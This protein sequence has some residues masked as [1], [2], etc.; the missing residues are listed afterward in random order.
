MNIFLR[1]SLHFICKKNSKLP[2]FPTIVS[3]LGIA[4]G[5]LSFLTVVTILN[6]FQDQMKSIISSINPNLTIFSPMGISDINFIEKKIKSLIGNEIRTMSPFIYQESILAYGNNT[7]AVYIRAIPG[8]QSASAKNLS[9]YINPTNALAT[10]D[11]KNSVKNAVILGKEL[12]EGLGVN[13]GNTVTLMIFETHHDK[14]PS[15]KY[16]KLIVTGFISA[17]LSQYDK[18][19]ILMN[20]Q[21][22]ARLFGSPNWASGFEIQLKNPNLALQLS[23]KYSQELP[24]SMIAWQEI[25]AGLFRQIT[26]DGSVIKFI[27]FIISIVGVFNIIVT[28]GLTVIDR[29]KQISLLRSLGAQKKHIIAIFVAIGGIIGICGALLGNLCAA[30][31]LWA[32]STIQLGDLN[33]FYYLNQIP[34]KFDIPLMII[35]SIVGIILS[36]IGA[37]HP[38]WKASK[39]QPIIGLKQ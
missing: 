20:F 18:Q 9:Q 29:S 22:G 12:A 24:Y 7:S 39:I 26:R 31:I 13:I 15:I 34:V 2:N 35:V 3:V 4:F 5:V 11:E 38:A 1:C 21:E 17:G 37:L 33:Q 28:L 14:P 10:L 6:A 36:S 19:Y 30:F 8:T 32:L 25:D 23:T 27:V 16:K